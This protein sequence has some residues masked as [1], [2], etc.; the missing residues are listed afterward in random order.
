MVKFPRKS[1][2]DKPFAEKIAKRVKRIPTSDL[3]TWA[4][5]SIYELSRVLSIYDRNRTVEA[6]KE[7]LIA[8]EALHAVAD[9]IA[10]RTSASI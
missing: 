1:K 9:E 4:D 3:V 5:Q 10:K 7:L 6:S 2:W 8:A